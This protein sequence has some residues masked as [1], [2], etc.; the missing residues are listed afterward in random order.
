M[1]ISYA[2]HKVL[3]YPYNIVLR[4]S[5]RSHNAYLKFDDN[6]E[7]ILNSEIVKKKEKKKRHRPS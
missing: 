4:W 2:V 6:C 1:F 7:I 5:N 3:R